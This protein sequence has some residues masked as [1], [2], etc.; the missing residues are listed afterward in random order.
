MSVDNGSVNT[1]FKL[2]HYQKGMSLPLACRVHLARPAC[3]VWPANPPTGQ[4][5]VW[6]L[7]ER[8]ERAEAVSERPELWDQ[9]D[10]KR[11]GVWVVLGPLGLAAAALGQRELWAQA[12]TKRLDV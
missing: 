12:D 2:T 7:W 1:E 3:R 11:W 5:V 9:A 10:I 8:S 4:P 6:D